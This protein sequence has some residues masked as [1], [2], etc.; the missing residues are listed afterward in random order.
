MGQS[1][2]NDRAKNATKSI[3][4]RV[5][6]HPQ[7]LPISFKME[8]C[9]QF[10]SSTS[11]F[12]VFPVW[13]DIEYVVQRSDHVKFPQWTITGHLI[14]FLGISPSLPPHTG[15]PSFGHRARRAPRATLVKSVNTV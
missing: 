3:K 11:A 7:A 12:V 13:S 8:R 5:D 4:I 9:L 10:C 6:T 2:P 14:H 1:L 15:R